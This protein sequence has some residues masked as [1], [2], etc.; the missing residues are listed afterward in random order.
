MNCL[1]LTNLKKQKSDLH[2]PRVGIGWKLTSKKLNRIVWG[3]ENA[4]KV[5]YGSCKTL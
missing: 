4:L 1:E 3:D 5:G 2:L